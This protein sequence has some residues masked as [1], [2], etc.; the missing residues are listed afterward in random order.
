MNNP[1]VSDI[2]RSQKESLLFREI[3][4]LFHTILIENPELSGL[5]VNR[6]KLSP[7]KGF[8]TV[9]FYTAEG[10]DYFHEKLKTLIL[11]KPA[12]RKALSQTIAG[13]Y[14]PDMVFKFDEQFEKQA[15]IESLLDKV[16]TELDTLDSSSSTSYQD[17]D[18]YDNSD[19]SSRIIDFDQ[20]ELDTFD[21]DSEH[22][23]T[24]ITPISKK[25]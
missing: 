13:R 12:M 5:F 21:L 6:I 25:K 11:Y 23:S 22:T 4:K 20:E 15:H 16:K 14:T 19:T 10:V 7:D 18:D 9:Y 17:Q 1:N 2:K 24:R 8:C 3:S